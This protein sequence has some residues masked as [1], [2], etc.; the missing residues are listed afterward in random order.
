VATTT[1]KSR[2][3]GLPPKIQLNE[4][5][6]QTQLSGGIYND[7]NST[8]VFSESVDL[9]YG[10]KLPAESR[11]LTT[12]LSSSLSAPGNVVSSISDTWTILSGTSTGLNELVQPYRDNNN[13]AVDG[14]STNTTFFSEGSTVEDVG[15]GFSQPL[16]SKTKIEIDISSNPCSFKSVISQSSATDTNGSGLGPF[17]YVSGASYPMA[18]FNFDTRIW[19]GIGTGWAL[20]SNNEVSAALDSTNFWNDQSVA[21]LESLDYAMIGFNPGILN[22]APKIVNQ[23]TSSTVAPPIATAAQQEEYAE[24]F[25]ASDFPR[26]DILGQRAAGQP[27]DSYGFPYAG[28]FHATSSQLLRM[29][30]YIS[31]PFLLEKIVLEISGAQFTMFDSIDTGGY[32]SITS[33]VVPAVIN[34]FFILNQKNNS[35]FSVR[36]ENYS[37]DAPRDL[38]FQSPSMVKL[39]A[40][41]SPQFVNSTRDLVTFAGISCYTNDITDRPTEEITWYTDILESAAAWALINS[42][43]GGATVGLSS[44]VFTPVN[45]GTNEFFGTPGTQTQ[46]FDILSNISRDLNIELSSSISSSIA[47]LSWTRN[48]SANIPVRSPNIVVQINTNSP[49]TNNGISAF[50]P[51]NFTS[52]EFG[53]SNGLGFELLSNRRQKI[54]F[55]NASEIKLNNGP[56]NNLLYGGR[57][58]TNSA[59][60]GKGVFEPIEFSNTNP[61]LLFPGDELVFGWQLPVVQNVGNKRDQISS[62]ENRQHFNSWTG[63]SIPASGSNRLV[64]I[65]QMSFDG[66]GK[67]VFYGSYVSDGMETHIDEAVVSTGAIR[68]IIGE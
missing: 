25:L 37:S 30:D 22:L 9:N 29:S 56:V 67:V 1:K 58:D 5:D 2:I 8:I 65:C 61:Y 10:S 66:P 43:I 57:I 59:F 3:R 44:Y 64:D 14:K 15:A 20:Q 60:S 45:I 68:G 42:Q 21:W 33:S 51:N 35:R 54:D 26:K 31:A 39:S 46:T 6:S 53:G 32:Y 38:H 62:A 63:L 4:S 24:Y 7:A 49:F 28:K 48:I 40:D 50:I 23:L 55:R 34:N 27:T 36:S 13:P 16:W 52:F 12:E 11:F 47:E 17:G 18:Y 41:S 19:E